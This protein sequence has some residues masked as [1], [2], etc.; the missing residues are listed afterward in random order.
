MCSDGTFVLFEDPAKY[1]SPVS[2]CV[3]CVVGQYTNVTGLVLCKSCLPLSSSH[4]YP[5]VQCHCGLHLRQLHCEHADV[6]RPCVQRVQDVQCFNVQGHFRPPGVLDVPLELKL[7]ER[8]RAA[9]ELQVRPGVLRQ[10]RGPLHDLGAKLLHVQEGHHGVHGVSGE[11]G[12]GE[13]EHDNAQLPQPNLQRHTSLDQMCVQCHGVRSGP[14]EARTILLLHIIS[15]RP[16][17]Q[18]LMVRTFL[19]V[20]MELGSYFLFLQ[21]QIK[22]NI[23]I[24]ICPRPRCLAVPLP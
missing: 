15:V 12:L 5:C 6:R 7:P 4:E 24:C 9:D 22:D 1:E 2:L 18:P 17:K 3:D 14:G 13:R 21:E 11:L 20:Y 8:E 16:S 10:G 23:I 19:K